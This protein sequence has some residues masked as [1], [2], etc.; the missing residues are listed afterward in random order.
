MV[1]TQFGTGEGTFKYDPVRV[2]KIF[3]KYIARGEK[4]MSMTYDSFFEKFIR[5]PFHPQYKR[6]YWLQMNN[7]LFLIF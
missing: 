7:E 2:R 3:I 6:S 1:Q 5:K 4:P